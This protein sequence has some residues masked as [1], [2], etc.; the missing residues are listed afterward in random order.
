[1]KKKFF[2]FAL[3]GLLF[4]GG[5]AAYAAGDQNKVTLKSGAE[6]LWSEVVSALNNPDVKVPQDVADALEKAQGD[7]D[8]A[9]EAQTSAPAAASAKLK[10]L[11]AAETAAEGAAKELK[12]LTDQRDHML[13]SEKEESKLPELLEQSITNAK[14]FQTAFNF[15][16]DADDDEDDG[17]TKTVALSYYVTGNDTKGYGLYLSF[18]P[19]TDSP[20]ATKWIA[21]P[22][23]NDF[24]K[25]LKGKEFGSVAVYL[26]KDPKTG[27]FYSGSSNGTANVVSDYK[28]SRSLMDVVVNFL[29]SLRT[30]KDYVVTGPTAAYTKLLGEIETAQAEATRTAGIVSSLEKEYR[31]LQNEATNAPAILASATAALNTAQK[32]Y[33]EAKAKAEANAFAEYSEISL[34]GDVTVETPIKSYNGTLNGNGYVISLGQ[35]VNHVFDSLTGKLVNVAFNG[36]ISDDMAGAK[37]ATVATFIGNTGAF[38]DAEGVRTS[39]EGAGEFGMMI[40]TKFGMDLVNSKL[41]SLSDES[42]V[43]DITI[44]KKE[45]DQQ[46]YV[47]LINDTFYNA[48][49]SEG[50]VIPANTFVQTKTSE[51]AIRALDNVVYNGKCQSVVITDTQVVD[52]KNVY[53]PFYCPMDITAEEVS[54]T[55]T[56]K[57]GTNAVCLPFEISYYGIGFTKE[58]VHLCEYDKESKDKFLFKVN[59]QS[60]AAN[61]P[62]VIVVDNKME[63]F[64][65]NIPKGTTIKKTPEKQIV[66]TT[67]A[68]GE[69]IAFGTLRTC[70]RE[71]FQGADDTAHKVFMLVTASDGTQS[72]K[73]MSATSNIAPFRTVVYS[74]D[75]RDKAPARSIAIVD[76]NGVDIT[77]QVTGIKNIQ[78]ETE[79]PFE[80]I[81]GNGEIIIEAEADYGQVEIYSVNGA[82]V[83]NANIVAGTN[84][85]NVNK[86]IYIVLGK[87][88]VVK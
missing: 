58:Q 15:Y 2:K 18:I 56:F 78:S 65:L 13:P 74:A 72:F 12:D 52:G 63:P 41:V 83:A 70:D 64:Q 21:N 28:Y 81:G 55:R 10:E 82:V 49:Y 9:V 44:C 36:T 14:T 88:V 31:N 8:D 22:I 67:G 57:K 30:N 42:L 20:N 26:G 69:S 87:K 62:G 1:M 77:D 40:R 25:A 37:F 39:V 17:G 80:V 11:E 23:L 68:D 46:E 76:E 3:L 84:N 51:A 61:T 16:Y 60:L 47:N 24:V 54:Y 45:G 59:G 79:L 19:T 73:A 71:D 48:S 5:V 34:K 85:V 66:S 35:D 29:V 7:Y 75:G 32:N 38:R 27:A 6:K 50:L 86:G 4:T 53:S 33:D 43:Y